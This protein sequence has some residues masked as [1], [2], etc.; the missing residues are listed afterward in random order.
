MLLL[1]AG[2]SGKS[3]LL[4]QMQL[5]YGQTWSPDQRDEHREVVYANTIQSMQVR[6]R[7][8]LSASRTSC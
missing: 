7:A 4:K 8:N 1:G 6:R 5:V 3:T 2:E